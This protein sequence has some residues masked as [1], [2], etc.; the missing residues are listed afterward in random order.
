M[1]E[2]TRDAQAEFFD[3]NPPLYP[4]PHLLRR[5]GLHRLY[6][7]REAFWSR[8]WQQLSPQAGT[9][10][11]DVGCGTGVWLDRLARSFGVC[12]VGLDVSKA[13]LSNA[14]NSS[15]TGNRYLCA[16]AG[17]LPLR[18][19]SFGIVFSLDALEHV[20]DQ[21]A[22]LREMGR[23]LEPGGELLLWS[24]NRSQ[25]FTWN[26]LLMQ[27]GVDVFE[28][29]AHDPGLM[30]EPEAVVTQLR[31]AGLSVESLDYFNAFFTLALDEAI[32]L[33]VVL[34]KQLGLFEQRSAFAN[35]LGEAFLWVTHLVTSIS[36]R[37]LHRLD[38]PWCRRGLSNGFLVI[39]SKPSMGA[40][41]SATRPVLGF[42]ARVPAPLG[43]DSMPWP[44]MPGGS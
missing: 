44:D 24:I 9:R 5:W 6:K 30:P 13:S 2:R 22:F 35:R 19:A 15:A 18:D 23:V 8:A 29:V 21:G 37:L 25:K 4:W 14:A 10:V 28:R 16:D 36:W 42:P 40:T 27:L 33:S 31:Q 38:R 32:M 34:L 3:A 1:S 26:W 11:L 43:M 7:P 20:A 39:A 17:S 12:G 41:E